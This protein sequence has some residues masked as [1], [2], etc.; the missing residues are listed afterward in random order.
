MFHA[1]SSPSLSRTVYLRWQREHFYPALSPPSTPPQ[2]AISRRRSAGIHRLPRHF[3]FSPLITLGGL[4]A[5]ITRPFSLQTFGIGLPAKGGEG[6]GK[7][8]RKRIDEG[9]GIR[10]WKFEKEENGDCREVGE[11]KMDRHDRGKGAGEGR[12]RPGLGQGRLDE[13]CRG[14]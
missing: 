9:E 5:F 4:N 14:Q 12:E 10:R 11:R 8:G 2:T 6:G 13:G 1:A 3:S 7:E